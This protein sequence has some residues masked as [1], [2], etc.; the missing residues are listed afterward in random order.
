MFNHHL[1]LNTIRF[2]DAAIFADSH[3]YL[4]RSYYLINSAGKEEISDRIALLAGTLCTILEFY[5]S[6]IALKYEYPLMLLTNT[7]EIFLKRL[8]RMKKIIAEEGSS[9]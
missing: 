8:K 6:S 4:K 1:A 7:K 9:D 2:K 5:A 3:E